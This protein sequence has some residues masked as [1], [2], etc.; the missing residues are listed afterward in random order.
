MNLYWNIY[1]TVTLLD[2]ICKVFVGVFS[3]RLVLLISKWVK[4][5]YRERNVWE[6]VEEETDNNHNG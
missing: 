5:A 3:I 4:T 6:R 2:A 1:Q